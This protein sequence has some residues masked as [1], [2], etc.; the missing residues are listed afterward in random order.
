MALANLVISPAVESIDN[1]A[2]RTG[3]DFGVYVDDLA[4]SGQRPRS[5]IGFV[6]RELARRKFRLAKRK[7]TVMGR[8][9]RQVVTGKVVNRKVSLG[10]HQL[11]VLRSRLY[12][13]LPSDKAE[14][15]RIAGSLAHVSSVSRSQAASLR[16]L[17]EN[18]TAKQVS[19]P[20][21]EPSDR[22]ANKC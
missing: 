22:P 2:K 20:R 1:T 21:P 11:K 19:S 4:L 16:R 8:G 6:K 13:L 3:H 5:L 14:A 17:R 9:D 12:R 10:R 15:K 18:L 7:T